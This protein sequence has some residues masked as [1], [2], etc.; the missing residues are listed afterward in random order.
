MTES[1]WKDAN[2]QKK[3][4]IRGVEQLAKVIELNDYQ[5]SEIE[6]T[7]KTLKNQGKEPLRIT[8]YYA[9]LMC[10][11]PFHPEMLDGEKSYKRL[12]PV[13]WQSVPTPANLLF[14]DTGAEG[15]M[16]ESSRS[17]GA[18][19]QRY[20]NRLALF[21]AENTSCA[22]YCVHCQRAKSLDGTVEV[23]TAE[24]NRG[25]FY[26]SYNKNINEVLVTGGD[27]LMISKNRLKYILEELS[28]IP[29]LRVIRI[30]TRVPV[31]LPMAITDDLL[32]LINVSA[33]QI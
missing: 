22:S 9:S 33:K 12:D 4:S 13:F 10:S 6:R 28:R 8:P 15:A 16:C 5:K 26:I 23:S 1:Q 19:Y 20:P 7:V 30:A 29:H 18:A 27:A 32:E 25:L 21:V 2:W 17:F 3:N 14:P 31:V 11:D 24:I